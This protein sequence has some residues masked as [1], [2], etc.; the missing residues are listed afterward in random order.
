MSRYVSAVSRLRELAEMQG[1]FFHGNSLRVV[2]GCTEGMVEQYI[3]RWLKSGYILRLGPRA[4]VFMNTFSPGWENRIESAI[5]AV[6]PGALLTGTAVLHEAGVTTQIPRV[7]TVLT[8]YQGPK[9]DRAIGYDI[10][11]GGL[12]SYR[13]NALGATTHRG[14]M[15]RA[16]LDL[17]A[18]YALEVEGVLHHDDIDWD[19]LEELAAP[20]TLRVA[21]SPR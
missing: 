19:Y 4:G 8:P 20:P 13:Q 6:H 5:Q 1:A 9:I 21:D 3:S 17:A 14:G 18:R 2:F 16:N 12:E 11:Y 7:R 15:P 10:V